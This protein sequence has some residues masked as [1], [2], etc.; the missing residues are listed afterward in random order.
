[1]HPQYIRRDVVPPEVVARER[2]VQESLLAS[3]KKP[4]EIIAN[5]GPGGEAD[6]RPSDAGNRSAD[7]TAR[8]CPPAG[9][10]R[11]QV[12][13]KY[14]RILLKLSGEALQD[15]ATQMGIAL[16]VVAELAREIQ[17]VHA[18]GVQ[19]AIVL[20]G[21][22]IFRGASDKPGEMDRA[23]ADYMGMLATVINSLALQDALERLGIQTRVM[24]AIEMQ[25]LAEPYIKRRALRHLEKDRIVIL[26]GGTGN[27]YFSTDTAASLRAMELRAEVILKGTKVD[28]VYDA[29]P[30][31]HR[32]AKR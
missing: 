14:Q 21:G 11:A 32:E 29:D 20:G 10:G 9:G 30:V 16:P 6:G 12:K 18:L 15:P 24:T 19:I 1:M 17:G 5:E 23:H 25:Q 2:E 3:E 28:G 31:T 8:L 4:P 27:P 22:N 26:A 13:P 7:Q